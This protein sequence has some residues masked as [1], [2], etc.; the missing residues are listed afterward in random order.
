M[1]SLTVFAGVNRCSCTSSWLVV[2]AAGPINKTAM[3]V[4]VAEEEER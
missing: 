1:L 2:A 4:K 3:I